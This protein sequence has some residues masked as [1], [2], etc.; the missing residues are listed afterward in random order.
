MNERLN[1]HVPFY[2]WELPAKVSSKGN[3][4][5]GVG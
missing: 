4:F 2:S 1:D 3:Q 5:S